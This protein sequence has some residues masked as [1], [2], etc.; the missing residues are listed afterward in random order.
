MA[1]PSTTRSKHRSRPARLVQWKSHGAAHLPGKNMSLEAGYVGNVGAWG[2][3]PHS[4]PRWPAPGYATPGAAKRVQS[5]A[6]CR[7]CAQVS[8]LKPQQCD[9]LQRVQYEHL[10]PDHGAEGRAG[11][12]R[13]HAVPPLQQF[14][15]ES[16]GPPVAIALPSIHRGH[17]SHWARPTR[18]AGT[19][20]FSSRLSSVS[21][22]V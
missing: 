18:R 15:V 11:V 10:G 13:S 9:A 8:R 3:S 17:G 5:V 16:D 19:T 20:R 6:A 4:P 2:D 21:A 22:T 12:R 7:P 1:A 14:P